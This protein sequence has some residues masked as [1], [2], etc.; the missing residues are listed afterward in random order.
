[1][2]TPVRGASLTGDRILETAV[3][4]DVLLIADEIDSFRFN[5]RLPDRDRLSNRDEQWT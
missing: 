5:L 4:M 2:D 3:E 1:M